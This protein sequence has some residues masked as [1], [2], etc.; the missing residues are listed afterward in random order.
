[1]SDTWQYDPAEVKVYIVALPTIIEIAGDFAPG[2]FIAMSRDVDRF[3]KHVGVDGQ[4]GRTKGWRSGRFSFSLEEGSPLNRALSLL[5]LAD[6]VLASG[7]AAILVRDRNGGD[8][9]FALHAWIVRPPDLEKAI[10]SG[11]KTWMWDCDDV[12]P[13][14]GGLD[15]I[16]GARSGLQ[17]G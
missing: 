11:I 5:H 8:L 6:D 7:V 15:Q 16:S 3:T 14:A 12:E 9:G 2:T 1:M 4:V 10:E 13:F 17:I